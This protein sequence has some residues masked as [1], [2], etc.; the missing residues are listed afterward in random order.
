MTA[1]AVEWIDADV[2]ARQPALEFRGIFAQIMEQAGNESRLFQAED[3]RKSGG[4]ASRLDQ[5]LGQALP[6]AIITRRA[7]M[8]VMNPSRRRQP[9]AVRLHIPS[10]STDG[11]TKYSRQQGTSIR[12]HA[13]CCRWIGVS[14]KRH[15]D[16]GSGP[17]PNGLQLSGSRSIERRTP[18]F[19][20][21]CA[22]MAAG[23]PAPS[24]RPTC[25]PTGLR[26]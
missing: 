25:A 8:G 6:V 26:H 4:E 15:P 22:A 11:G 19:W 17:C 3:L 5:M 13:L 18:R 2:G 7:G 10:T 20:R 12:R 21:R 23:I 16:L 1:P 14:F 9:A 24:A